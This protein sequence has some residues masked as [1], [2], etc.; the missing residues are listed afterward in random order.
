MRIANRQL[1]LGCLVV[2]SVVWMGGV[3]KSQA[4]TPPPQMYPQIVRLSYVE[5]DVRLARGLAGEKA[6][7]DEWEKVAVDVPIY[8]GFTLVTG[9]GG[10]VEIEFEDASHVYLNE[11]SV[12]SFPVLNA[13]ASSRHTELDL[14]SGVM[15]IDA[16]GSLPGS[17]GVIVVKT[18]ANNFWFRSPWKTFVRVNSYLDA[19]ELTPMVDHT[20]ISTPLGPSDSSAGQKLVFAAGEKIPLVAS[21]GPNPYAEW[22]AWVRARV[23]SNTEAMN[24]AMKQAGLSSP[25]PGLTEMAAA[26]SFFDCA[27]YGKCWEPKDGWESGGGSSGASES[28]SEARY[29]AAPAV[30][31]LA[32]QHTQ[33]GSPAAM[34]MS[35]AQPC[36]QTDR[37][38]CIVEDDYFPCSPYAMRDFYDRDP[39]TGRLKLIFA[40]SDTGPYMYPRPYLWGV[41]HTG[42][43]IRHEHRY[44]WVAGPHRHHRWGVRWVKVNGKVG[45]VPVH[46]RD[47][48]GKEP[49]NIK[50]GVYVDA[51]KK[52]HGTE[53][54]HVSDPVKLLD[55]T[56][57]E[58]AKLTFPPL[59]KTE[60]PHMEA[61]QLHETVE[62]RGDGAARPAALM[63]DHKT[64][65]FNVAHT[66]IEGGREHQITVPVGG[67]SDVGMNRGGEGMNRGGES[68]ANH[69]GAQSGG[70][71][72][73]GGSRSFSGGNEGAHASAPSSSAPS[74]SSSSS[75]A[76][77]GGGA[78]H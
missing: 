39:A 10:R 24:A 11:N 3:V 60:A 73:G 30:M 18:P 49:L 42:S 32:A 76:S 13:N 33:A 51:G 25:V 40:E 57:K 21:P 4:E 62:H 74:S 35:V 17:M 19:M 66:V 9:A 64:G 69:G 53:L 8:S 14:V 67:R 20:K 52:E 44:A 36:S 23:A 29:E 22:D 68:Y 12:L 43:W 71:S 2:G 41:C 5:G 55:G 46:P 1:R 38:K 27:P 77:S 45:Y 61:R 72:S 63:F 58:F 50:H 65:S 34:P 75:S 47:V 15:T 54:V 59:P 28:G 70:F 78:H 26:G 7:R 48:A 56:P 37:S 16:E 6:T 31:N